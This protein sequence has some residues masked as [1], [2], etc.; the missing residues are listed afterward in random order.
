MNNRQE[1]NHDDLLEQATRAIRE[2]PIPDVPPSSALSEFVSTLGA[3]SQQHRNSGFMNS[4]PAMQPLAKLMT[5]A[6][7]LLILGGV[8]AWMIIAGG[9][10]T[11]ALADVATV[12]DKIHSVTCTMTVTHEGAE[13]VT[14]KA[15]YLDPSRHRMESSRG[16]I[17]IYDKSKMITLVPERKSAFV[18]DLEN[19]PKGGVVQHWL[20]EVREEV[21]NAIGGSQDSIEELGQDQIDGRDAVGFRLRVRNRELRVWADPATALPIRVE[22]TSGIMKPKYH[23]VMNKFRYNVALD[24]SLFSLE[25]PEGYLVQATSINAAAPQERD[26]VELL[27]VH[28]N[29]QTDSLFPPTL[30]ASGLER[31]VTT[32]IQN[33]IDAKFGDWRA[34]PATRKQVMQSEEFTAFMDLSKKVARGLGF[35]QELPPDV[36]WHYAGKHVRLDTP[37][38]PI[39]WYRPTGNKRYRVIYAD[40][41]VEEVSAE[42]LQGFPAASGS[43]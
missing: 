39:F 42:A 19:A 9:G 40:L 11:I 43:E 1:S 2:T 28:A 10:A 20:E 27:R 15:M 29:Q 37:D 41:H 30:A 13:P 17:M 25:P 18:L 8:L 7:S 36:D 26:F 14:L 6:A 21:R 32:G 3:G 38:R 23:R 33:K 35:L 31:G 5:V 22:S 24:E 16:M 4:G 12:L 34:D